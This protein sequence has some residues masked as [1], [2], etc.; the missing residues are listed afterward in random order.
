MPTDRPSGA[1]DT[2]QSRGTPP[3]A[4]LATVRCTYCRDR[5]WTM[6]RDSTIGGHAFR[7]CPCCNPGGKEMLK[8]DNNDK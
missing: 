6:R 1:G 7:P 5:R 3:L 2:L 8:G 4:T